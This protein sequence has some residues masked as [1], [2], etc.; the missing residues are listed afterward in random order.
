MS[1]KVKRASEESNVVLVDGGDV[2]NDSR[3]REEE[4]E[5]EEEEENVEDSATEATSQ[6]G[7]SE[8]SS[9][10]DNGYVICGQVEVTLD[11]ESVPSLVRRSWVHASVCA[12]PTAESVRNSTTRRY[13][14]AFLKRHRRHFSRW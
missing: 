10:L 2:F 3:D 13:E 8:E 7:G 14:K 9:I 4:E 11:Y 6:S 5:E 1:R 12:R